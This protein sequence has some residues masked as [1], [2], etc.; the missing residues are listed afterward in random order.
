M[1]SMTEPESVSAILPL[2]VVAQLEQPQKLTAFAI[3][4]R[5]RLAGAAG[6]GEQIRMADAGRNLVLQGRDG[7]LANHVRSAGDAIFDTGHGAIGYKTAAEHAV[8]LLCVQMQA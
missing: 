6:A 2:A 4:G 5:S 8:A 7:R 3:F 1:M